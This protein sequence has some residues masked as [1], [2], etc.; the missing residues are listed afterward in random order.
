MD[1]I[2]LYKDIKSYLKKHFDFRDSRECSVVIAWALGTYAYK[3]FNAY[4][5]LVFYGP[6][7]SGKSKMLTFLSKVCCNPQYTI[8]PSTAAM[9]RIIQKWKPTLLL[10]EFNLFRSERG[11]TDR[12]VVAMLRQGYKKGGK[13]PRCEKLRLRTE[14]GSRELQ[15]VVFYEV[16]CPVAFAGLTIDDDQL[17]DRSIAINLVR[18]NNIFITNTCI[19]DVWFHKDKMVTWEGLINCISKSIDEEEVKKTAVGIDECMIPISGRDRE[20]W[21]PLLSVA[22]YISGGNHSE[23]WDDLVDY[24]QEY[25]RKKQEEDLSSFDL[26]VLSEIGRLND[27]SQFQ[28]KDISELMNQGVSRV[29]DQVSS[30]AVGHALKR[31]GIPFRINTGR[32][33]YSLKEEEYKLL[34]QRF[35]ITDE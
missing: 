34:K 1:K 12:E 19:D 30:H 24:M 33:Y 2:Q 17:L 9:F 4:P 25:I 28:A 21:S 27:I 10:D 6:K 32:K 20:L 7:Q 13:I 8:I 31:L 15:E 3:A 18:S 29:T 35:G 5:R 23:F 14:D 11:Y 16:Y 26:S 22:Y